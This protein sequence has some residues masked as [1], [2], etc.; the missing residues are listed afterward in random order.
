MSELDIRN[1]QRTRHVD[2][3]QFRRVARALLIDLIQ[4]AE[5]ELGVH[6]VDAREMA[7]LNRTYLHQEGSTDVITF[8]YG[9]KEP[10]PSSAFPAGSATTQ[11]RR[12]RL[13]EGKRSG[14]LASRLPSSGAPGGGSSVVRNKLHGEIFI[15]LDEAVAQAR[16]FGA[17]WQSELVRY[18]VHGMLHLRGYNDSRTSA[19]R[20]MNRQENRLLRQ[21]A[22]RFPLHRLSKASR[23]AD[24]RITNRKSQIG[25]SRRRFPL[26][27][28][29]R[30]PRVRP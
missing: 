1:R 12:D 8:D 2:L 16:Q 5:Y 20:Q 28:L 18:L 15:C 6:L 22:R 23:P 21:L 17:T 7:R 24:A 19:R 26:S 25:N 14:M 10:N 27:K 9:S 13:Q 3:R 11:K 29:E 4:S 30:K